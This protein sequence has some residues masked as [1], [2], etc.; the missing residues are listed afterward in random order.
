M[1]DETDHPDDEQELF[2]HF[3]ILVDK[4]LSPHR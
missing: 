1:I 2:E 4:G 3:R